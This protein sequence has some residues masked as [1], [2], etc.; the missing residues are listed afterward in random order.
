M[1]RY[2]IKSLSSNSEIKTLKIMARKAM[3]SYCKRV[4]DSHHSF[5]LVCA[6]STVFNERVWKLAEKISL[7][8]LKA[9][10]VLSLR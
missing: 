9:A 1:C 4:M 6:T 3:E 8:K 2:L 5:C 7:N 10:I